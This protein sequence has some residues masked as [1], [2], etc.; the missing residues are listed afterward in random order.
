[1]QNLTVRMQLSLAF[2]SLAALVLGVSLLSL[3]DL[4]SLNETFSYIVHQSSVQELRAIDVRA[5]ANRRALAVRNLVLVQTPAE[6]DKEHAEMTRAGEDVQAAL[7]AL[8]ASLAAEEQPDPRDRELLG[9]IQQVE[10]AYAPVAASIAALAMAGQRDEA[11]A[12]MNTDCRPLLASLREATGDFVAYSQ[13]QSKATLQASEAAYATQRAVLASL[14]ALSL[15]VAAAMGW[16]I[17]RRLVGA[18]GAEPAD[19]NAVAQRVADGDLSP[20]RGAEAAPARSVLAAMAHMQRKLVH[21]IGQV[22]ASSDSIA[23]ASAQIAMGNA[24]LSG[25]TEQQASALQQTAASMQQMTESV[26]VNAENA[27]QARQLASAAAEVAS[28]GGEVVGHVVQTMQGITESSR[29][30]GD[31]IGV[32]DGIAFQTNILALNASVEAARAGE[33]GRGF[34]VVASEVRGLAQR[35]ANAAREIKSLIGESIGQVETGSELVGQAGRTMD[36][37]VRQVRRVNDL[38]NEIGASTLQQSSGITQVNQAVASIDQ[39]T[40]QNAALVEE[41]AAAAESLSQQAKGLAQ[42][43]SLFRIAAQRDDAP[44]PGANAHATPSA[45]CL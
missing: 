41:S 25:R 5:A 30:I 39:G 40:Q 18:L 2:A 10:K 33:Q 3:Y 9:R 42:V 17:T 8:Q 34:A 26:R 45:A 11:I 20:L 23:T 22:R 27:Q 35:S 19:L 36:D 12:R 6:R 44:A 7:D 24:D 1:M 15:A 43:I 13:Q 16:W 31:I 14:C 29:R 37:I 32:I 4:R 28:H 38:I 21:L